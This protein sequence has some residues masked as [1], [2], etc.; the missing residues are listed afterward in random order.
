MKKTRF[1]DEIV[2]TVLFLV[3][4]PIFMMIE[5]FDHFY[6]FTRKYEHLEVDELIVFL[7]LFSLITVIYAWKKK[8]DLK[9][10]KERLLTYY[11]FD[12]LTGLENRESMLIDLKESS[13]EAYVVLINVIDF[14]TINNTLGFIESDK[15]L[16]KTS[17]FL[18]DIINQK[19]NTKVYRLYGNEFG[20]IYDRN[21]EVGKVCREIKNEFET[22]SIEH[23]NNEFKLSINISYSNVSPRLLSA[24]S[25]MAKCKEGLIEIVPFSGTFKFNENRDTLNLLK[26]IK[27]ALLEDT[28]TPVYQPI[29]DNKTGKVFKY[30]TLARIKH[31]DEKLL[32]PYFFIELSKKFKLY[33]SITKAMITKSF[34]DFKDKNIPFSINFS[35][36]DIHN[37][38]ILEFFY[39]QLKKYKNTAAYL[40]IEILETESIEN[41]EELLTFRKNIKEYDC[42]LAIDDFGSGYSNWVHILKLKPDFIKIDGSLIENLLE[43]GNL[44]LVKTIVRFAKENKIKTIAEFVSSEELALLVKK[45]NIDYS[46][47]YYYSEPKPIHHF[48]V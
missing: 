14:K 47:G 45:I 7:V 20:F 42:C 48:K 29:I 23:A 25:A 5:P 35:Y 38:D 12:H 1:R 6:E 22:A 24:T 16:V 13:D 44:S 19:L 17:I 2:A 18:L 41:Y 10:N 28:I 3:L 46:Q 27:T 4:L 26:V 37:E 15:L 32:T 43:D 9:E 30:E 21:M 34:E 36:I 8:K 11:K 40:T 31:D 39:T 33:P